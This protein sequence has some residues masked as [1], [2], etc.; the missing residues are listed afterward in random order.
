MGK[1]DYALTASDSIEQSFTY[2]LSS[3]PEGLFASFLTFSRREGS[4]PNAFTFV[5][6]SNYMRTHPMPNTVPPMW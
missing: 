6:V 3:A 5:D 1:S 2:A 4:G